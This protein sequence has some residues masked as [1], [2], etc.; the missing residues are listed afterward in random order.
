MHK[1]EPSYRHTLR[2]LEQ[3]LRRCAMSAKEI[4]DHMNCSKVTAYARLR[5]LEFRC[6]IPLKKKQRD[7]GKKGP[8]SVVYYIEN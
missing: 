7:T 5:A 2:A 1:I 6:S 8:P 4:A 3:M